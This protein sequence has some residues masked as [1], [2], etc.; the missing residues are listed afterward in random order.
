MEINASTF[1]A[2]CL[3]FLAR[4]EKHGTEIVIT[5]R[6]KPVARLVPVSE[7]PTPIGILGALHGSGRAACD[8]VG[9][10]EEEWTLDT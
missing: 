4:T 6:G 5:R 8:I 3:H 9:P 1:K 7:A 10:T 2:K